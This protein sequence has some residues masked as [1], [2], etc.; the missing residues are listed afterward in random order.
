MASYLNDSGRARLERLCGPSAGDWIRIAPSAPG[1]ERIEACFGGHGYDPHRHDVYAI[2]ITLSGVQSFRYRGTAER[3]LAGEMFLLHP[4]ELHDGSAGTD[5]GFRYRGLYIAP[6]LIRAALGGRASLPFQRAPVSRD[7]RLAEAILPALEDL[8]RPLDELL[9]DQVVFELAEALAG[10]KADAIPAAHWRAVVQ[11]REM[12]DAHL[13]DGIG[14]A[15]L[16]AA[17]GLSRYALAR[18][19]RAC[20][21]TSPYRYLLMRRLDHARGLIRRGM[22]LAE[23]AAASGFADQGHMTR[24]FRK[25]YG[26]TPGRWAAITRAVG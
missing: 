23:A 2:G 4:D 21:G 15:A 18:Q 12:I 6:E 1:I 26:L 14:T 13:Q 7:K 24:H 3:C 9:R 11:A 17:T 19:F 8:D 5:D 22:P 20:L 16:E 10:E 25:A